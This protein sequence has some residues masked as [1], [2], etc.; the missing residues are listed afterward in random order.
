MFIKFIYFTSIFTTSSSSCPH[1]LQHYSQFL[2]YSLYY[3]ET[4]L[5]NKLITILIIILFRLLFTNKGQEPKLFSVYNGQVHAR[6]HTTIVKQ[7]YFTFWGRE[8]RVILDENLQ[9]SSCPCFRHKAYVGRSIVSLMGN[10]GTK[11]RWVANVTPQPLYLQA[12]D[13]GPNW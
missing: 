2:N 3:S 6:T 7:A 4:S 8:M 12:K 11:C 9:G 1:I 10:L 5:F 13:G